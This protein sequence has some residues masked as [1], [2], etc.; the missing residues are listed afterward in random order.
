MLYQ[1]QK[2]SVNGSYQYSAQNLIICK[3]GKTQS[4]VE[5]KQDADLG[6]I[7]K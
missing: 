6:L 5:V 1:R 3:K 4:T 2:G 7:N